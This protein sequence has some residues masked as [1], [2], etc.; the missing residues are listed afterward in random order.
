VRH[1]PGTVAWRC[2]GGLTCPAQAKE[3]LK[4]F[5]SRAAFDIEGL[6]D[7]A[8][9]AFYEEGRIRNPAD[10][11]RLPTYVGLKPLS[12]KEGWGAK[13]VENLFAAIEARRT[14]SLERFIYALGIP[15]IG[16]AT[17]RLLA[18]HY[19]TFEGLQ[20]AVAVARDPESPAWKDL[21]GI[22][23]IGETVAGELL[24]FFAE[25]H[26]QTAV[27]DLLAH[28]TPEGAV[29][30]EAVDSPLSGKTVVFTGT[31]TKLSRSEAKARAQAL[32][33]KVAGSVSAKTD[34]VVAGEV[35]G[36]K[37]KTAEALGVAVIDEDAFLVMI[38]G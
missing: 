2:T 4:H 29:K 1:D 8:V 20:G 6:G 37:L 12:A 10:I 9:E 23:S 31:L 21:I 33:A 35:A 14:I 11:F 25:A 17:A 24:A 5:V 34:L 32:G 36:S 26:N 16:Q 22:E 38:G 3:R 18:Q 7:K 30:I 27:A 15:Q 28:V 13:S 19:E